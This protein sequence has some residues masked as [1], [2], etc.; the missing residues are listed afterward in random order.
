MNTNNSRNQNQVLA[1]SCIYEYLTRA[2]MGHDIDV[3]ELL[4]RVCD[5]PFEDIDTFI[6]E[7]VIKVIK[8][9]QVIVSELQANMKKWKFSRLNRV[10]QSILLLSLA[11]YRFIGE[12]DREVVIDIAVRMAKRYL[13]SGDYKFIN[14]VLDNTL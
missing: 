4:E 2:E 9:H 10:A 11:H 14:A 13:D 3:K 12:V 1:M 7:V 6:S 5:A 8:N